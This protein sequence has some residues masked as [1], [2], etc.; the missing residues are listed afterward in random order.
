MTYTTNHT[1][2]QKLRMG[3]EMAWFQFREF[4]RP[5]IARRGMDY[6]L[7]VQEVDVLIQDVLLACHQEHVLENYDRERGRFRDYLRTVTSRHASRLLAARPATLS[8]ESVQE[9]LETDELEQAWEA[10]C[11]EFL[12]QKA[13]EELRNTLDEKTYMAFEMHV[14]NKRPA[15]EVAAILEM[16]PNQVYV[17]RTRTTERLKEIVERLQREL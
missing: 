3:D 10:E 16:T 9:S 17:I 11:Q 6:G 14:L 13:L 1:L 8:L 5:L 7:N 12:Q 15:A 2:L 4:Y